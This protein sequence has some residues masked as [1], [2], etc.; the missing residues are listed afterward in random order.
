MKVEAYAADGTTLLA[1]G[2]LDSADNQVDLTTST[3]KFKAVFP[4]TDGALFPNQ[5][6]NAR[7]TLYYAR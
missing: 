5:F 7:V 3:V 6:V 1:T 4:N 2:R